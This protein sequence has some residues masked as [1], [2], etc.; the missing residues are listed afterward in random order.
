MAFLLP[1]SQTHLPSSHHSPQTSPLSNE[2]FHRFTAT[3]SCQ[4]PHTASPTPVEIPICVHTHFYTLI[5]RHCP[6]TVLHLT[7]PLD[8]WFHRK[9]LALARFQCVN[10]KERFTSLTYTV[11]HVYFLVLIFHQISTSQLQ[12]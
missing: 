2:K 11:C 5:N 10:L 3:V 9:I 4:P 7:G 12:Q 6:L 1:S 8:F